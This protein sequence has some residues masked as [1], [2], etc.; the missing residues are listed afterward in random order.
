M[1][2]VRRDAARANKRDGTYRRRMGAS[3]PA[4]PG[5]AGNERPQAWRRLA[6]FLRSPEV[7]GDLLQLLKTVVATTLAW[8]ISVMLLDSQLPF[9]APWTALLTVQATVYRSISD[10]VQTWVASAL[11]VGVSFLIGSFLGVGVWT[12]AL[13]VL[14]GLLGA[15]IPW[16][17]HQGAAIATT[18]VFVLGSGFGD[19]AP[20][21]NDRMLEVGLGVGVGIVVN[22]LVV[23]PL[24]DRQAA[25]QVDSV[26]REMG[27]ILVEMADDLDSSW[28]G[29]HADKWIRETVA[30]DRQLES[31]GH[32]VQFARESSHF[33]PRRKGTRPRVSQRPTHQLRESAQ[34][35]YEE[36]LARVGE[37]IS[38]LRNL[39]RTISESTYDQ[40]QWDERFRS[41]WT[42]ILR[43]AGNAVHDPDADVAPIF[44]RL[45]SLAR[46]MSR[47]DGLPPGDHWPIYGSLIT[48]LRHIAVIVDDVASTRRAREASRPNPQ[49]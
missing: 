36:I 34:V 15:R 40:S 33:N 43:D 5:D 14:V 39:A 1:T 6:A 18:G 21:L 16:L 28:D 45:Q 38:H 35:S 22:L 32:A 3:P 37:G 25:A 24:W 19:Q 20:L 46:H 27:A 10:G 4:R 9:L 47:D 12:F 17:R 2:D 31:V 30:L 23:P 41:E 8:W 11:G 29:D 48:S 44:D 13:A 7:L 42:A 49:A 26:N